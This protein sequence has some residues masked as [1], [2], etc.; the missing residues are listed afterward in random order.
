[1]T[2]VQAQPTWRDEFVDALADSRLS[3]IFVAKA[4]FGTLLTGWLAMRFHLASPGTAMLTF[5]IVMY[6]QSGMVLAKSFYRALGTVV[7]C[8]AGVLMISLFAQNRVLLLLA[9]AIWTG[10]CAS[11]GATHRYFVQSYGYLLA[12]VTALIVA[13][14]V[15]NAPD[16][17]FQSAIMRGSE[18]MLGIIVAG[19]TIDGIFP[20]R[21]SNALRGTI[22][23]QFL[24]FTAFVRESLPSAVKDDD[25]SLL[26]FVRQV[27]D[28]ETLRMA[29]VFEDAGV[30]A[31]SPRLRRLN[32]RFMA[33][34]TTYHSLFR[35]LSHLTNVEHLKAASHLRDLLVRVSEVV[36]QVDGDAP[37]LEQAGTL[38]RGL[39]QARPEI[40]ERIAQV[41]EELADDPS[42]KL[43]FE[44][45]A[46]LCLRFIRELRGYATAYQGLAQPVSNA[47]RGGHPEADFVNRDDW[48]N[49]LSAFIRTVLVLLPAGWFWIQT[50]WTGGMFSMLFGGVLCA[51]LSMMPVN[52]RVP[53]KMMGRFFT[54]AGIAAFFCLFV[55]LPRIDG[56][57]VLAAVLVPF[58]IVGYYLLSRPPTYMMGRMSVLGLMIFLEAPLRPATLMQY[59]LPTFT[60]SFFGLMFGL[61][62]ASTMFSIF[63]T[64]AEN[65]FLYRHTLNR[66]RSGVVHAAHDP[67]RGARHR[68]ESMSRGQF[69]EIIAV[70]A[71][72]SET[73]R[74]LL[75]WM[76]SVIASGR[77][78]LELRHDL[79]AAPPALVQPLRDTVEAI[80]EV[81]RKPSHARHEQA[82]RAIAEAMRVARQYRIDTVMRH[83][84]RLEIAFSRPDA[85]LAQF[86]A[87]PS[88]NSEAGEVA[89]AA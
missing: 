4:V 62:L 21:L 65:R 85:V 76:L 60:S 86:I 2:E 38:S 78:A 29:V 59:D 41:R 31:K 74:T 82:R 13:I 1:M 35:L 81:Y 37:V 40:R 61:V 66:L 33:A 57:V 50:G 5:G 55:I 8:V 26:A 28:L 87:P 11:G 14:P 20:Q 15:V 6:P 75:G 54:Y 77:I 30:R 49:G 63:A 64:A 3:W 45:G 22:R 47:R 52:P 56:F 88:S 51:I 84:H 58:L 16:Q 72:D 36:G 44:A 39:R 43:D 89:H 80:S 67:L 10:L 24:D 27:G 7:G 71:A 19:V 18:V 12:A 73:S 25:E 68:L 34:S 83:L 17:V 46:E 32:Q 42:Q 48:V 23:K 69:L 53:I 79:L 9:L 70:S